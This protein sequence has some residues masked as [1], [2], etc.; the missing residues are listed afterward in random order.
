[1][2]EEPYL[3]IESSTISDE[4]SGFPDHSMTRDD[5]DD[6]IL[7]IRATDSTYGFWIA[8]ESCLFLITPS[9]SVGYL[10]QCLPGF[11]LE[12]CS[13][14]CE[15][16][17]ECPSSSGEIF[18][19]LE[20]GFLEDRAFVLFLSFRR[21]PFFLYWCGDTSFSLIRWARKWPLCFAR[22]DKTQFFE[23]FLQLLRIR[24]L[25]HDE[26]CITRES[27]EVSDGGGDD[28]G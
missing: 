26:M 28:E 8:C 2:F 14:W 23:F 13:T 20:S 16:D 5:D 3:P 19:E 27:D 18:I 21:N 25:E 15:W 6:G 11:L 22:D 10:L 4:L 17:V 12:L 24:K 7:I 1:M 9:F